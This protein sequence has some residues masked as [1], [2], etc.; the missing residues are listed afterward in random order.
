M[1]LQIILGCAAFGALTLLSG[2]APGNPNPMQQLESALTPP[3]AQPHAA[4]QP[5]VAQ[6]GMTSTSYA[7]KLIT[8][9]GGA[10]LN[11]WTVPTPVLLHGKIV[12]TSDGYALQAEEKVKFTGL[13][14]LV[15]WSG[16]VWDTPWLLPWSAKS[17]TLPGPIGKTE[18][19]WVRFGWAM[20]G[21]NIKSIALAPPGTQSIAYAPGSQ[22]TESTYIAPP[23]APVVVQPSAPVSQRVMSVI[24]VQKSLN[25]FRF[26]VGKPDGILGPITRKQLMRF[27]AAAHLPVTGKIDA[28][29]SAAIRDNYKNA[30][31]MG[32]APG[33]DMQYPIQAS[34]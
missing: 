32:D 13:K 19:Y 18:A 15:F 22:I 14:T 8:I 34:T 24:E 25:D 16:S 10:F 21:P 2:C 31:P 9:N 30:E 3:A 1:K 12:S 26:Y 7:S 6:S 29:T 20:V 27:Q 4:V 11:T 23:P 17:Q 5:P 33:A 28:A